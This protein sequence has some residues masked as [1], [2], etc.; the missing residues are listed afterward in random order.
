MHEKASDGK[1]GFLV[2]ANWTDAPDIMCKAMTVGFDESLVDSDDPSIIGQVGTR[3]MVVTDRA[4]H[5][6]RGVNYR[7]KLPLQLL[8][9]INVHIPKP[10]AES[11]AAAIKAA[12]V[13][14]TESVLTT[15]R[16]RCRL[17]AIFKLLS[18]M[19]KPKPRISRRLV[20]LL[21][22]PRSSHQYCQ[23]R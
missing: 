16:S 14:L 4:Y 17:K 7:S 2:Y 11:C 22:R 18:W 19:E 21:T 9:L 3:C 12:G 1:A 6:M 8:S 15:M 5:L 10:W 23:L 20:K 13:S